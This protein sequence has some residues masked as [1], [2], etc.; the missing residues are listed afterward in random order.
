MS[1]PS[2]E[3]NCLAVIEAEIAL[4]EK[5][6][7]MGVGSLRA[8]EKMLRKLNTIRTNIMVAPAAEAKPRAARNSVAGAVLAAIMNHTQPM[9]LASLGADIG[10]SRSSIRKALAALQ[11]AGKVAEN[12]R[13]E[14]G[15]RA[16]DPASPKASQDA[17][18]KAAE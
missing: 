2:K 3:D 18:A 12:A 14:W 9:S 16:A 8:A 1:R 11:K 6:V 10:Y 13:G 17:P 15:L 7:E 5:E 4:A